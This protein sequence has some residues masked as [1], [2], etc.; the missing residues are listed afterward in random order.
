[1][2]RYMLGAVAVFML[3]DASPSDDVAGYV[4]TAFER[5]RVEVPCPVDLPPPCYGT[6]LP[7]V[8]QCVVIAHN[9]PTEAAFQA[10][11]LNPDPHS[12]LYGCVRAVDTSGNMSECVTQEVF[13]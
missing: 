2:I 13:F 8:T 12:I 4:C 10:V 7:L 3:F 9:D 6:S 5:H 11:A 1:M